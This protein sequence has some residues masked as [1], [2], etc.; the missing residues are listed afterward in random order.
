MSD[1][2]K[3]WFL[4]IALA[5]CV[6]ASACG[7]KKKKRKRGGS[8]SANEAPAMTSVDNV[9]D[10]VDEKVDSK[11]VAKA[12]K[13]NKKGYRH[14]RK[15]RYEK[16]EQEYL[17]ALALNPGLIKARYNLACVYALMGNHDEALGLLTQL[18]SQGCVYC[19]D[20]LTRVL[21]DP[22]FKSMKNDDRLIA[23][24][25]DVTVSEP[26]Y[27]EAWKQF[28]GR[29]F[30]MAHFDKTFAAGRAWRVVAY[31]P[32]MYESKYQDVYNKE[33]L[34]KLLNKKFLFSHDYTNEKNPD[35][36]SLNVDGKWRCKNRCCKQVRPDCEQV[37]AGMSVDAMVEICFYPESPKIA[38]PV[39]IKFYCC[40][41][42]M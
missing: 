2:R 29:D 15:K 39:K 21:D 27:E 11:S 26:D 4:C 1:N 6:G 3:R 34:L 24:V 22:D 16:A 37:M 32:G 20:R 12:A 30:T 41:C 36:P 28:K 9:P 40:E 7:D 19:L 33:A 17:K 13:H 10:L 23:L 5:L 42:S 25:S 38:L 18:K 8:S 14:Y 31:M 35:I